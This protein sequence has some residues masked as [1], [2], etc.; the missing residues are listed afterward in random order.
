MYL[1]KWEFFKSKRVS[2]SIE[3][4]LDILVWEGFY[5]F[6]LHEGGGMMPE[7]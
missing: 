7:K 2:S 3:A 6:I 5:L 1:I 4:A